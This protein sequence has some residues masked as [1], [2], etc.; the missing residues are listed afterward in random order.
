LDRWLGAPQYRS[1]RGGREREKSCPA[2]NRTVPATGYGKV[3]LK[4]ML[5]DE[6]VGM[7]C[8]YNRLIFVSSGDDNEPSDFI[9]T[10]QMD[11]VYKHADEFISQKQ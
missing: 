3:I 6:F 5:K 9:I 1:G 4:L 2:G 11:G 10:V 7:E 8:G